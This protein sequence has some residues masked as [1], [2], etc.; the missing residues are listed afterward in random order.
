MEKNQNRSGLIFGAILI[1]IGVLF[2]VGQLVD[3][4]NWGDFWPF[5]IIGV[6]VVFFAG[7]ILG[8]KSAG[9]LAIPA[10]IFS[11]I[12]LILLVQNAL[13]LWET[14]AYAW[15]LIVASVGAGIAIYGYLSDK[16][17][18]V[19]SGWETLRAGLTLFLVFGI[20]ME[21][22]FSFTGVSGR[23]NQLLLAVLLVALGVLQFVWRVVRL[24]VNPEA[25]GDEG[26][27]LMGPIILT[28]IGALAILTVLNVLA[29]GDLFKLLSLWPLLLVAAGLQLI[30]GRRSPWLSAL[31]GILLVAAVLTVALAGDRLG[32]NLGVPFPI[33]I[34]GEPWEITER[35]QGS[36]QMG[37]RVF[38]VNDFDSVSLELI[39][40][41]E[42][43]QGERE[44]LTILAEENILDV[45]QVD[46]R[47]DRLVI[48]A[49]RGIGLEPKRTITYKLEV[50]D[51]AEVEISSAGEVLIPSLRT[52]GLELSSSGV[53]SFKLAD[54]Q[55]ERLDV[56][57]S[58][59]GSVDAAGRA[60]RLSVRISGA[61]N[62]QGADLQAQDAEANI[63]GAGN[64]TLWVE[65]ILDARISGVGS[66]AYYGDPRLTQNI[67]GL[68][69]VR[70]LGGK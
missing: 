36:G 1:A 59:S 9:P 64:A 8:G 51:L 7:M 65:D 63:S 41:L 57:I 60:D 50:I 49:A 22:I 52:E 61:G 38:E 47:G 16:P 20:I 66:I 15:A 12:G 40:R 31:I 39:G 24:L 23:Q 68:G 13:G 14:W 17:E 56:S 44:A 18:S 58:G 19:K 33:V 27:D 11:G 4:F 42:I 6:G 35:I 2:F 32:I 69:S 10:S 37:E 62:F 30:F 34:S 55:A 70:R 26:R 5:I 25:A 29:L 54:L 43:V 28:G 45:I 21:F 3:F 48:S 67:S 53:G 46:V